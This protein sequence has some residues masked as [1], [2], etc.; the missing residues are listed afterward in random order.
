[1]GRPFLWGMPLCYGLP[2]SLRDV[3]LPRAA[4][5]L[6]AAPFCLSWIT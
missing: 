4:R 2:L 6:L 5:S 3:P 1:M